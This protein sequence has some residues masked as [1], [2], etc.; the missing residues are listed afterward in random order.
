VGDLV[1]NYFLFSL[2]FGEFCFSHNGY[3]WRPEQTLL[4]STR[5]YSHEIARFI[6]N[7]FKGK[8]CLYVCL[9]MVDKT[10]LDITTDML[11]LLNITPYAPSEH[12][13]IYEIKV[14]SE[15]KIPSSSPTSSPAIYLNVTG[16]QCYHHQYYLR[17]W[18]L[19]LINERF[20][21]GNSRNKSFNNSRNLSKDIHTF[22]QIL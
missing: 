19:Y 13:C 21:P 1:F 12:V 10:K 5:K 20:S 11:D 2:I 15:Y 16:S 8:Q 6:N 3:A 14:A 17:M 4:Y 9:N 18:G 22:N 7:K